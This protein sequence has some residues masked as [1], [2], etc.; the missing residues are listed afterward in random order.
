MYLRIAASI[1]V[2]AV[3]VASANAEPGPIR[4]KSG[5]LTLVSRSPQQIADELTVSAT[6]AAGPTH[7]ILQF[8]QPV[9]AEVRAKLAAGG[10]TLLDYL[11][12]NG[13]FAT[14]SPNALNAAAL[15]DVPSLT[16]SAAVEQAHKLHRDLIAGRLH[17]WMVVGANP[18]PANAEQPNADPI[19]GVYI[20]FHAD[21]A[22]EPEGAATVQRYGAF[23]RSRL[24]PVNSLVIELP[25]SR[26]KQLA[27]EDVVSWIEP[28]L[29]QLSEVNAD[30]AVRTGA[31]IV[32]AVPYSLDGS[33]ITALV[34]DGGQ[35]RTAHQEFGGRAQ[36][37][38]GDG[39]AISSHSTHVAGTIGA[40]GVNAA[41]KGM[42]PAVSI[43]SYGHQTGGTGWLLYTD[44][45]DIQNDYTAA[46]NTYGA[47][48][49]NNS[50][51]SNTA[52][53]NFPCEFEGDYGIVDALIDSIA[54]GSVS[55]GGAAFRIVWANGNERQT[56]RCNDTTINAG[57]H[58]T[59]PPACA[60][61][62]ITVG[63]LNSN[64]DSM[65]SF[66]SWGPA[67]DDRMKPDIA[68]PGC[69][70]GG[71]G[72][73]TSSTSTSNTSYGVMCGTSMSAPTVTG[74]SALLLQDYCA[75]FPARCPGGNS[76]D[77]LNSTLK[78]LLAHTAVD[79]GNPGPD[80]QY[81]YG[82]VRIQPAI[83][84]MRT[85]RFLEG[86]VSQ[87]GVYSI[88]VQVNPGDTVL[89]VTLAWDDPPGTPNV[90][91]AL[92]NDLDLVVIDPSN[93]QRFPW[94]LGGLFN[95]TGNAV[96]TQK[97]SVDNIEQVYVASP[98]LGLYRVEV[99]GYSVPQGPQSFSLCASPT[100]QSCSQIG[101]AAL[102]NSKYGCGSTASLTVIDCD[103]NSNN[104]VAESVNVSI[105]STTE[106]GG[107]TVTLT[108]T[109]PATAKFTGTISLSTTNSPGVLQVANGDTVTMTYVDADD[110]QG[111]LNV[112]V[113]SAATVDCVLPAISD[114]R[115]S[116]VR[117][118]SATVT[119]VTNENTN[120]TVRF[121]A[122]CGS[123]S[124]SSGEIGF[125]TSHTVIL[126]SLNPLTTYFLAVDATDPGG[127]LVTADNGGACYSFTTTAI[128]DFLS[129][130]FSASDDDLANKS[131]M[132][133]PQNV[134]GQYVA[135]TS[136]IA[137][138][139]TDPT[140]GTVITAWAPMPNTT[141]PADDGT[142]VLAVSGGNTV[143]LHGV[144]Y[145]SLIVS[146]N[147]NIHFAFP[148]GDFAQTLAKHFAQP[149]ISAFWID[150]ILTAQGTCSWKQLSDRF[151]VTWDNVPEYSTT[152][153][154]PGNTFQVEMFFDGRIRLSYLAMAA[155]NGIT[156]LSPGGGLSPDFVETDL[157]AEA[158]CGPQ[159]PPYAYGDSVMAAVNTLKN[160]S[161]TAFDYN[162]DSLTHAITT[163]PW[164][165]TL[166]D[167]V[168]G[169]TIVSTPYTL[170]GGGNVVRYTPAPGFVGADYFQFKANDGGTPTTGGDSNI[171]S[172]DITV[173]LSSAPAISFP[174]DINP[175]WTLG[176]SWVFGVPAGLCGDPASGFT[177]SNVYG[178][179][180]TGTGCYT[181]NFS[182]IRYLTTTGIDCTGLSGVTL[183]FRRWLNIETA[184]NDRANIQVSNNGTT[185]T[186]IFNHAGGTLTETSW[187]LHT[188]NISAVAD[189]KP[190]VF[191]RWGMGP[192]N[193]SVTM[194][195]WNID[196]VEILASTPTPCDSTLH[197][198][199]NFSTVINGA[200]IPKFVAVLTDP[201]SATTQELCA[202][203][204]YT[205]GA[206]DM[207]DATELVNLLLNITVP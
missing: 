199:M 130:D 80:Y 73:V 74:V 191:I 186:E 172:V 11:G 28:P 144:S 146:T 142:I 96:Q 61:N 129:E 60:K 203:D 179:V 177:G 64:N 176:T 55:A 171:A 190:T 192:T 143:K 101:Y 156:G 170:A 115:I 30:N 111:G 117:S 121:G 56:A 43:V 98:P 44:P 127:N 97:N 109:G 4:F 79:L 95:P 88:F 114:V 112:P 120:G 27:N 166:F 139:P 86:S 24:A 36:V 54:R 160:V 84:H 13:F 103:L 113:N 42:A 185:W 51:G 41:A 196:D 189:G 59:P 173:A 140:G 110:G 100:L 25:Y 32:Q 14:V 125:K 198:D 92:V 63:A 15:G 168:A 147:G 145:T 118:R 89:K 45:G 132:F 40:A 58:K 138:L 102:D 181:S 165:G 119:F 78:I 52:T 154:G 162:G 87:N 1:T 149:R 67:D 76:P 180:L 148:D 99:H 18:A 34:Y 62:H 187:S 20:K 131:I 107:E 206:L 10:V 19:V 123:L 164:H 21:V 50:I 22:L 106:P 3:A 204:C 65:T 135:C 47:D 126:S 175:G 157:S 193:A 105:A 184:P 183:R 77:M 39:T 94:T 12:D 133:T 35:V 194:G 136:A 200:D 66:S 104:G 81:G 137:S 167:P 46:I 91:P 195:G 155:V 9:T 163:L 90:S 152:G 141:A 2:L 150:L 161:L 159:F 8:E 188:Y 70:A 75:Q 83:D 153:T 169:G 49:A 174:L 202:A 23:V 108:E 122:S 17:D 57:Y 31:N 207:L 26:I 5:N 151:A 116:N 134:S 205:D 38:A 128:P 85:G 53:N 6:R 71:D 82:S 33:G 68:G 182:P 197:G 124:G 16:R 69:Q 37:G 48:I 72:G 201:G 7:V 178:Y 93:N 158:D 29:P